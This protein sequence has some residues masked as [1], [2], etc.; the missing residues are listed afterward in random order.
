MRWQDQWRAVEFSLRRNSPAERLA[1]SRGFVITRRQAVRA[2]VE[3]PQLRSLLRAGAW[4]RPVRGVISPIAV[5]VPPQLNSP[6]DYLAARSAHALR[7]T[8]A[9]LVR[10]GQVITGPSAA[11]LHGLPLYVDPR[12]VHLTA[13]RPATPGHHGS[14]HVRPA[15]LA[16]HEVTEWFGAPVSTVARTIVDLAR[17]GRRDGIVAVDAATRVGLVDEASIDEALA[18]CAGWPGIRRARGV[19]ELASSMSESPLESI[20][21]LAIHDS[22]LPIPELQVEIWDPI[23]RVMWRVDM[24]WRSRRLILEADGRVKYVADALWRERR[25]EERLR[26]LG[27]R[28]VRVFWDD[29]VRGWVATEARIRAE[30]AAPPPI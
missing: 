13:G 23:T 20:T 22:G 19:L 24:L 10:P 8:G 15:T 6:Q 9:A 11:I 28:L 27:Y 2:G 12:R 18:R 17:H 16:E 21:R 3:E 29:V 5:A 4:S 14:A 1:A 30:L 25:R 7:A 26:R